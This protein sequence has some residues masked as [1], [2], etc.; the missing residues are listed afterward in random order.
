[1]T[2]KISIQIKKKNENNVHYFITRH[3]VIAT[4]IVINSRHN[5]VNLVCWCRITVCAKDFGKVNCKLSRK[6]YFPIV[7]GS[8]TGKRTD[9]YICILRNRVTQY[10]SCN[11]WRVSVLKSPISSHFYLPILGNVIETCTVCV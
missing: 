5:K 10:V 1:M 11:L 3:G 2:V 4:G 7:I 9:K 8:F 6:R